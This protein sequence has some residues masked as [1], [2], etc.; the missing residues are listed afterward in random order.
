MKKWWVGVVLFF[1]INTLQAQSN[2]QLWFE[3]MLNHPFANVYNIEGTFT[4]S[5][6][7]DKPRW[8]TYEF[9]VTPER[10]I[11]QHFDVLAAL[12]VSSTTQNDTIDSYEIRPMI[13]ARVHFTPHQRILTRLFLRF[14]QRNLKSTETDDW[15][16]SGRIRTRLETQIPFNK[17]TMFAGDGLWYGIVDAEWFFVVDQDVQERF[18]NRFRFR[19]GVG[20][21]LSY[22]WRFELMYTLQKSKHTIEDNDYTSTDN[23]FR[24]R[25]KHYLNKTKPSKASGTGN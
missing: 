4:Y 11:T 8:K 1:A 17:P 5:T 7:L 22:T 25:V 15:E 19:A 23:I 2:E 18:A 20:Y 10:S 6:L 16:K 9:Q 13:G 21:R 14:E 3:Y 12:L 24:V